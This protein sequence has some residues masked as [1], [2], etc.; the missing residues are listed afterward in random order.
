MGMTIFFI[1]ISF[2]CEWRI[3]PEDDRFPHRTLNGPAVI[4]GAETVGI[5]VVS[6]TPDLSHVTVQHLKGMSTVVWREGGGK[7]ERLHYKNWD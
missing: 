6:R 2:F 5:S 3:S 4:C 1:M 7:N